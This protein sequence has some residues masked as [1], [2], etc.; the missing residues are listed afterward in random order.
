[1]HGGKQI[2]NIKVKLTELEWLPDRT[3]LIG[4]PGI[5][6][7]EY[8][9]RI[10]KKEATKLGRTFVDLREADK[11][12]L[13]DILHHPEKYYVYLRV[14]ATHVFPEDI[15][16][17]R[18]ENN[19]NNRYV[20]FITPK[21]LHIMTLKG[22]A[23]LLFLDELS[24]VQRDDQMAMYYSLILEKEFG[25][26]AKLS[27][28]IKVI[29]AANDQEWSELARGLPKPLRNRM[30][31]L[32]VTAPTVEEW[33][34]FMNQEHG[35]DWDKLT[36][37]YL[38]MYPEDFIRAPPQDD[39]FTAFPTPRSWTTL[40]LTLKQLENQNLREQN[41]RE[42]I[43]VGTVGPEVA[44]KFI[45]VIRD[46][47][48]LPEIIKMLEREPTHFKELTVTE[49]ILVIHYLASHY[50]EYINIISHLEDEYLIMLIMLIPQQKRLQFLAHNRD[51]AKKVAHRIASIQ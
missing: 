8:V 34:Q 14:L 23:G 5:G 15:N 41:L 45:T 4:E 32:Y 10:A 40:A 20:E 16:L 43:V 29:A 26:G 50:D 27:P 28:N 37:A 19:E 25:W 48:K 39:G 51:I 35:E 2:T 9:K 12:M 13:E 47:T 21:A 18:F 3:L 7:T 36:A 38:M 44:A 24:N 17:P 33:I 30:I 42:A 6:K 1:M 31:V 11:E 22:I 49:K 46:A